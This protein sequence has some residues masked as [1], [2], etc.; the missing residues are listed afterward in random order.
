MP[1]LPVRWI[2]AA[3]LAA[4]FA[5]TPSPVWAD[6]APSGR[7][8]LQTAGL[9]G[10]APL[11]SLSAPAETEVSDLQL[12]GTTTVPLTPTGETEQRRITEAVQRVVRQRLTHG[13]FCATAH[14][15]PA[16]RIE[17]EL[18]VA[19][20]GQT[21]VSSDDAPAFADCLAPLV[22]AWPLPSEARGSRTTIRYATPATTT[23]R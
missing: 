20:T 6:S 2:P 15:V 16:G 9:A 18:H 11:H 14:P 21:R 4:S 19:S 12:S 22:A 13:T 8:E 7:V 10:Y 17:V 5:T 23:T 3:C 1:P